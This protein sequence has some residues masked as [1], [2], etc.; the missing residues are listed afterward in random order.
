M[1]TATKNCKEKIFGNLKQEFRAA[2]P[3]ESSGS[4]ADEKDR[5]PAL[6]EQREEAQAER[7]RKRES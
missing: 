2:I 1:K 7:E 3:E 4:V 5:F 6:V